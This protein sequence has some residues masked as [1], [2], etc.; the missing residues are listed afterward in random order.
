MKVRQLLCILAG[1]LFCGSELISAQQ[2]TLTEAATFKPDKLKKLGWRKLHGVLVKNHVVHA[3]QPDM[4]HGEQ[5]ILFVQVGQLD[6]ARKLIIELRQKEKLP[7]V[8][9]EEHLLF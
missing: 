5:N 1:V 8:L 9:P 4:F 6:L 3:A 7:I 2:M